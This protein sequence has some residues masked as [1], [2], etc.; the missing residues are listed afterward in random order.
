M[1]RA[2]DWENS[3]DLMM[4]ITRRQTQTQTQKAL[5]LNSSF[6]LRLR[7]LPPV[8]SFTIPSPTTTILSFPSNTHHTDRSSLFYPCTFTK[9]NNN[10]I[11]DSFPRNGISSIIPS[12][13]PPQ[14][15]HTGFPY[16]R[17]LISTTSTRLYGIRG[18]RSWFESQ[19]PDA[20]ITIHHPP[21]TLDG[22]KNQKKKRKK[23]RNSK[24]VFN[25]Q[26]QSHSQTQSKEQQQQSQQQQ[27]KQQQKDETI[28]F[29]TDTFD[30]VLIDVN[31]LLHLTLRR[32]Q[33]DG[34]ALTLFIKELDRCCIIARPTKSIV[35]A[36][37]GPAS[38]AKLATQRRRRYG[39]VVRGE[40]KR[41]QLDILVKR[42]IL[43]GNE[44]DHEH[45]GGVV[46]ENRKVN[47]NDDANGIKLQS[48]TQTQTQTQKGMKYMNKKK[49]KS[50]KTKKK[51]EAKHIK[52]EKTLCITPGTHF[53]ERAHD[54]FL[55]WAWQRL[56][57]PYGPLTNV[58]FY[59]SPSTV[60]GEGEVKLLDWLLQA[61]CGLQHQENTVSSEYF[62]KHEGI[63]QRG[64][65]V[66]IMGGD[67]DLVLEGLVIAPRITH[68]LYVILPSTRSQSYAVSLW[69]TTRTL[70]YLLGPNLD[71]NDMM[72]VRMDL[73]LLL[74]M[75]GNDYLP[76]LRGSL[77]FNLLFNTYMKL[78]KVWLKE[79]KAEK[80]LNNI[81][82][83]DDGQ[84]IASNSKDDSGES[85]RNTSS[86]RQKGAKPFLI[87]PETLEFN[88][89]FC[90]AFFR[91]L[92]NMAPKYF[93]QPSEMSPYKTGN[94]PLS[95]LHIL[96]D[97]GLLPKP[98]RFMTLPDSSRPS[99]SSS[100]SNTTR[101]KEEKIGL[102]KTRGELRKK[103][104]GCAF[105]EEEYELQIDKDKKVET[106]NGNN[107]DL[108][109]ETEILRLT[110]GHGGTSTKKYVFETRHIIHSP[111]RKTKQ[112]LAKIALE[113]IVGKDYFESLGCD[114]EDDDDSI[115]N[116]SNE[117]TEAERSSI[118]GNADDFESLDEDVGEDENEDDDEDQDHLDLENDYS[119]FGS[120]SSV[121]YSW[122]VDLA[123]AC[124]VQDYLGG[125]L[126]NLAT[127]QDGV[128][129]N[130]AYNYGRRMSP[131]AREIL[132][133]MENSRKNGVCLGREQLLGNSF[134]SP[135]NAGLACLAALPSQVQNLVPEPYRWLA[136]NNT[137]EQIYASC[138]DPEANVFDIELF[139]NLC[140]KE[141]ESM[142][143]A[144]GTTKN[145]IKENSAKIRNGKKIVIGDKVWTVLYKTNKPVPRPFAPPHPFSNHLQSLRQNNRI[146]V[147]LM[148][149]AEKPRWLQ[150]EVT[151][152]PKRCKDSISAY[153]DETIQDESNKLFDMSSILNDSS[154]QPI[155]LEDVSYK[156]AYS[157]DLS[158][159]KVVKKKNKIVNNSTLKN[160][161]GVLDI[162]SSTAFDDFQDISEE[163]AYITD[164]NLNGRN[165]VELIQN[166][167]DAR[168]FDSIE[169]AIEP[170]VLLD[171]NTSTENV[172]GETITLNLHIR[173]ANKNRAYQHRRNPVGIARKLIKKKIA[174]MALDD[175]LGCKNIWR[176]I[177]FDDL[178]QRM[179]SSLTESNNR[180]Q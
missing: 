88:L 84:R 140:E 55:Y 11:H 110:L 63:V 121:G 120:I 118:N 85:S 176:D 133:F 150:N 93:T 98:A 68:N 1:I 104:Q 34:H 153:S 86:N 125:L 127:Y 145:I 158:R 144:Q 6:T 162:G 28:H 95:H 82:N 48:Q 137:V 46:D 157:Q 168:V 87:D 119:N 12:S 32:S 149:A 45:E 20:M 131:T 18:F 151:I 107:S 154:G 148:M 169:W 122:E 173:K 92:A 96:V 49:F 60:P 37:D 163:D 136:E 44:Q 70:S 99:S 170:L 47:G 113:E 26:S 143:T 78:L 74:I 7:F 123:A 38:A 89:P 54:A 51:R 146:Q 75:N 50:R 91:I 61:G 159:K 73:V 139:R 43:F 114:I 58:R 142:S 155:P 152:L 52:D 103:D 138:M 13:Q 179:I 59:I 135:L 17:S 29:S 128:C 69:E 112:I 180:N 24:D 117:L 130:Y 25:L 65:S 15:R 83:D 166:L 132:E 14:T 101:T 116:G 178:K 19:F 171:D 175:L 77:G 53:M 72:R 62:L 64:D 81:H 161:F 22:K 40:L 5:D 174:S 3:S 164:V 115:V 27:Q 147:K 172:V 126:W 9:M 10:Y 35:L 66:A 57:N 33:S 129:S 67:A 23:K 141:L 167:V 30:H 105:S 100:S 79:E 8:L 2:I 97:S 160:E 102:D 4:I 21:S 42:G 71:P 90:I 41:E 31:Q 111:L 39:T 109:E 94:T 76:K 156:K 108:M 36:F 177:T 56:S 124:K 16:P 106:L 80:I 165:S 134:V